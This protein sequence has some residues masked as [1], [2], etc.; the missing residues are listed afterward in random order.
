MY[1]EAV[2][3]KVR[4]N[5]AKKTPTYVL[6]AGGLTPETNYMFWYQGATEEDVYLLGSE[7]TTKSGR[8]HMQGT[9]TG[10]TLSDLQWGQFLVTEAGLES[11]E[12]P[13]H[14]FIAAGGDHSLAVTCSGQVYAWGGNTSWQ[15]GQGEDDLEDYGDC[16]P[17][18]VH[19]G[20]D[21]PIPVN[22]ANAV[23]VVGGGF[24]SMV[25]M[26]WGGSVY[27]WGS[28]SDGQLGIG[29][30]YDYTCIPRGVMANV[31][32]L[33][34]GLNHSL[35]VVEEYGRRSLWA[36]G[37]N[38][39]GQLGIGT[40]DDHTVPYQVLGPHDGGEDYLTD[41]VDVAAG[42]HHTLAVKGNGTVYAWG[43]GSHGQLGIH[44]DNDH[45]IPYQVHGPD[46]VGYLEDIVKVAA[47]ANFSL[48]LKR[49]GTV[50]AWGEGGYG[51]LGIHSDNDHTIPYQVHGPDNV[52]YLFGIIEVEAGDY[53]SLAL[54][55]DGTVWAWGAGGHGQLGVNSDNDHSIPYQ[56]HGPGNVGYLTGIGPTCPNTP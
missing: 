51:Q 49:D 39:R 5:T 26:N 29:R 27:A 53:F 19:T 7:R 15:C 44:S 14:K 36:W 33:A 2:V 52:G 50:W 34:A 20:Y 18:P 6:G 24:H 13:R 23:E 3:G 8:L 25:L 9:F 12:E 4:V 1:D 45:T 28:N 41:V 55:N 30:D 48:A 37:A 16:S 43:E 54:R 11:I 31:T 47:G 46:N 40:K 10:A 21:V 56:V 22:T 17:N 32:K 35:A 42:D 38:G